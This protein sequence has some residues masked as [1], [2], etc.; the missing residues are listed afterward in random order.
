MYV[1]IHLMWDTLL[2]AMNISY[3]H[4]LIKN[5]VWPILRH[6]RAKEEIEA[7]IEKKEKSG[8]CRVTTEKGKITLP[9]SHG[10]MEIHRLVKMGSFEF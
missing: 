2:C 9:I 6:N 5:L 1:Y 7:E 8:R 10:H 3:Y 4:W